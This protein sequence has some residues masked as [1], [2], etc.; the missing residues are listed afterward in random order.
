MSRK[1]EILGSLL[2]LFLLA[3]SL[4]AANRA[5][6]A[7][8]PTA[9]APASAS[10]P[11][12]DVTIYS[13]TPVHLHA[14]DDSGVMKTLPSDYGV[15]GSRIYFRNVFVGSAG[16]WFMQ[17]ALASGGHD[18]IWV[19]RLAFGSHHECSKNGATLPLTFITG[20]CRLSDCDT[21]SCLNS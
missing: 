14:S 6:A 15:T 20:G 21:E 17:V 10:N 8:A 3:V 12:S 9:A 19:Q 16:H 2:P 7:P 4:A 11:C 1:R 5:S 13:P 18:Y